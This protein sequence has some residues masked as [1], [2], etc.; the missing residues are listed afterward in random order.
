MTDSTHTAAWQRLPQIV[1]FA[2]R[3]SFTETYGFAGNSGKVNLEGQLLCA[4][5]RPS[6]TIYVFMHPT[7][8]LQLLP[9]PMALADRGLHV[10]CAASRYA[11]NDS[12]LIMEKVVI[13]LG[14]WL[15]HA[16]EVLGY[17]RVILVGWSGGGSLSLFYQ[18]Q[19]E[20]TDVTHTPAGDP[21]DL[22]AEKLLPADGVIFVAAHLSRAETLTEWIDPSVIDELDPDRRNLTFDIYSPEC[23]AQPPYTADFIAA[24]RTAQIAR[25]RKITAWCQEKLE[26][27]RAAKTGEMERA[28]VVHRT[29][30]DVRWLDPSVDPNGREPGRCYMGDPRAVNVGPV[31]L[32]RYSTLRSWLSQWSYDLSN[33]KGPANAAKI[34][35]SSVLQIENTADDAVPATHNPTIHAALATADKRLLRIDG[36]THYYVGQP[37]LLEQSID[38]VTAW[39]REKRL[40]LD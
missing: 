40:L 39:S 28:F 19:A 14:Q 27:L 26:Q 4:A 1:S 32:A 10:L 6:S 24:F 13:D 2:D 22:A 38:A 37:E 8:T 5:D 3:V 30:C 9:M 12:A 25:N 15:R 23:P 21:I 34:R 35:H 31:G 36:A 7:S 20:K 33:A 11:K 17:R 29:M 18:A 16:R